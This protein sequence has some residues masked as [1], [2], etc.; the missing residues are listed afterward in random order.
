MA[1]TKAGSGAPTSRAVR[2]VIEPGSGTECT[3]CGER[4]KFQAKVRAEQVICNVYVDG[5]WDRVEHYHLDCY[6]KAG[7]PYG[8]PEA[9]TP[10]T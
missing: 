4:I 1:T 10:K 2:R 9:P 8:E 6:T 3:E 7:E 5:S